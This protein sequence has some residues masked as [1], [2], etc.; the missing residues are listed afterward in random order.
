MTCKFWLAPL[1]LS[2]NHGFSPTELNRIRKMIQS[3]LQEIIEA[4]HEHCG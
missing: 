2:E 4:W 3:N 1:A